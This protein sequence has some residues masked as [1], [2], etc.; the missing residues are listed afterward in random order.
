M[1]G[2]KKNLRKERRNKIQFRIDSRHSKLRFFSFISVLIYVNIKK[3]KF[4]TKEFNKKVMIW[5]IIKQNTSRFCTVLSD[6]WGA[7]SHGTKTIRNTAT[8]DYQVFSLFQSDRSQV[9]HDCQN[10]H[11]KEKESAVWH[12]AAAQTKAKTCPQCDEGRTLPVAAEKLKLPART[13]NHTGTSFYCAW[14]TT[15]PQKLAGHLHSIWTKKREGMERGY[16]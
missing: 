10:I 9:S 3:R 5:K 13:L 11:M 2:E 6:G 15:I 1:T 14:G 16:L 7:T 8:P 4:L 12:S